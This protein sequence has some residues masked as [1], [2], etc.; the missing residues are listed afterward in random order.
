METLAILNANYPSLNNFLLAELDMKAKLF[1][2]ARAE[3]EMFLIDNPATKKIAKLV[4]AYE[5]QVNKNKKAALSWE[6]RAKTCEDDCV[7]VCSNCGEISSKWKPFCKKCGR[8]NPFQ[9]FLCVKE[10]NK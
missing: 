4:A 7:W 2:K 5:K 8:F 6:K 3:F 9:W 1:D 10:R